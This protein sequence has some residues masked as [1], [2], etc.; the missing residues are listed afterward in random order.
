MHFNPY[1]LITLTHEYIIILIPMQIYKIEMSFVTFN[2]ISRL[3]THMKGQY[4]H[5][6]F[7]LK[8]FV[9]RFGPE[10]L[11]G[12]DDSYRTFTGR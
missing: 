11:K 10:T 3:L 4:L 5:Q 12:L 8:K 9:C 1:C 6:K 7:G 2:L